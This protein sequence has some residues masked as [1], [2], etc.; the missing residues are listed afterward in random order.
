MQQS[1]VRTKIVLIAASF[2]LP[3]GVLLYLTVANINLRID[4]ARKELMGTAY[5]RPLTSLMEDV[6]GFQIQT[7]GTGCA[8]S[9]QKV[10]ASFSRMEEADRRFGINLEFTPEGLGKRGRS[11]LTVASLR[12]RWNGI[13]AAGCPAAEAGAAALTADLRAMI[14]HA[15]DTSNLILDPDLDSYYLMDAVVAALP[16]TFLRQPAI[17]RDANDPV[18]ANV[19][20]AI[21]R[22][23]DIDRIVSSVKTAINEDPSFYGSSAT[24]SARMTPAL[25]K[26]ETAA[27]RFGGLAAKSGSASPPEELRTAGGESIAASYAL[28]RTAADELDALLEARI[29]DSISYRAWALSLAGI[30]IAASY[31]LS[32]IFMR[33]IT[34]PLDGLIR[35]LGPGAS[36]LSECVNRI[37]DVKG[38]ESKN[39][40]AQIIC[41][42]LNAHAEDMRKAVYQLSIHVNGAT[43]AQPSPVE[44]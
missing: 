31:L 26:Y 44:A 13:K 14:T 22:E 11:N 39:V 41:E 38:A 33:S 36:L 15:G 3:L 16:Q 12:Q 9:A 30:A 4:F 32:W 37:S 24:L 2:S 35:S 10:D 40:E 29:R 23:A 34:R 17:L 28:W 42:E 27:S 5:L 25:A 20:A 18:K 43:E 1:S 19:H 6:Q 8:Q 7:P 21:L